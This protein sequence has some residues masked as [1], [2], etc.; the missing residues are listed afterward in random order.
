VGTTD[1]DFAGD[2]DRLHATAEEVGY[3]LAET[4]RVFP[5]ARVGPADV[6]YTY[7]GVRPLTYEEGKRSWQVSRAHKVIVEGEGENFLSLTGVKLTCYRQ[8][9]EEAV[10]RISALVKR[11]EPVRTHRLALDGLDTEIPLLEARIPVD[12]AA[13]GARYDVEPALLETLVETYGRR[14]REV[15]DRTLQ[16]PDLKARLCPSNPD[17]VAELAHAVEAEAAVSLTD[18]LLRRTGIGTSLCLGRDCAEAI[19]ARMAGLCGW[20]RARQERELAAFWEEV[21]LGQR[22]REGGAASEKRA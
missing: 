2:L 16:R 5:G 19:A 22:F 9:A 12:A 17:I 10:D 13:E 15:L 11:G 18:V 8:Q 1:T 4:R 3:L 20:D 7:A 6:I 21:A 14:Y